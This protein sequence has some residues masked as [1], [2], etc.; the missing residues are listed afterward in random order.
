MQPRQKQNLPDS[1]QEG[2]LN[3]DYHSEWLLIQQAQH[4]EVPTRFMDWS[5]DWRVALFFAVSNRC[6]KEQEQDDLHD[7]QFWIFLV[8]EEIWISD[9][10]ES[11][12]I[13]QDPFEFNETRV[14]NSSTLHSS[15][16]LIQIAQRRKNRQRGRFCIQSYKDVMTPLEKQESY[17][18][19]LHKIIIPAK[20]KK[21]IREQ[22]GI[23]WDALYVS[24]TPQEKEI[25]EKIEKIVRT[26]KQKYFPAIVNA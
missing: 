23:T 24:E 19:Y 21:T 1:I 4:Y 2:Y 10:Q 25:T 26:L 18:P 15:N 6:K 13:N 12:Y 16:Y 8:P 20:F 5:G 9:G 11:D 17:K 22:L 14:L 7:G 3:G